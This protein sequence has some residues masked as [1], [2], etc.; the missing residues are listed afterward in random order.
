MALRLAGLEGS[1]EYFR[2]LFARVGETD[3][4]LAAHEQAREAFARRRDPPFLPHLSLVYGR[5]PASTRRS[6]VA[7][8]EAEIP[9]SFVAVR[10][11]VVRTE[12]P[13]GEW[14]RLDSQELTSDGG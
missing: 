13:P 12:G 8:L 7:E 4:L 3:Q 1:D 11:E 2:A 9:R 10:L 14:R 5:L 6:L